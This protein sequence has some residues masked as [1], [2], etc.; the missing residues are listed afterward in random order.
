MRKGQRTSL[1]AVVFATL[2][3]HLI[4]QV[5]PALV[6]RVKIKESDLK[7]LSEVSSRSYSETKVLTKNK[8]VIS[9]PLISSFSQRT[10]PKDLISHQDQEFLAQDEP[11]QNLKAPE[12]IPIQISP[13]IHGCAHNGNPINDP[14]IKLYPKTGFYNEDGNQK[15]EGLADDN[16]AVEDQI[17]GNGDDHEDENTDEED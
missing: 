17:E 9:H 13:L 3:L 1:I 11:T 14:S 7:L 8:R 6:Y 2:A 10:L 5:S 12:S 16:D 15:E 4:Q